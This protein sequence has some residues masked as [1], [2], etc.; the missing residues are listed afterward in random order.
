MTFILGSKCSDGVVLVADRKITLTD[1]TGMYFDYRDKLFAVLRH[2]MFGSSGSTGN[3]EQFRGRIRNHISTNTVS[4]NDIILVLSDHVYTLNE[5]YKYRNETV[6]DILVGIS[7]PD[8]DSTLTYINAYG[9][10]N[11]IPKYQAIG[12]GARYAKAFLERAWNPEMTTEQVAEVGYFIIKYV[13]KFRLDLSV[14]LDSNRPQ[15]WYIPNRYEEN[16]QHEVVRNDDRQATDIELEQMAVR[17]EKRLRTHEKH[18]VK[19]FKE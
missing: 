7:Y 14:G 2:V 1:D 17:V 15:V 10:P 19:L 6:F 11:T 5:R 9:L 13:E 16:E 8:R 4:V 3:Y 12:I 18:L